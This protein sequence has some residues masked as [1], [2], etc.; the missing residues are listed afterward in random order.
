MGEQK[1]TFN[2]NGVCYPDEHYMVNLESRLVQI[3]ALVDRGK[4][5]V[6]N[7]GRQYGKTTVLQALG[8]CLCQEY[9][10]FSMDF[11]QMS[12]A[13]FQDEYRF[14]DA[15]INNVLQL[16][17]SKSKKTDGLAKEG[18]LMLEK[19]FETERGNIDLPQMFGCLSK[20]CAS[21][22]KPVVLIIDEVDNASNDQVFLDFLSQLRA[23]YLNR[24]ERTTFRSV[25]LAGVYD[26]KNLKQKIRIEGERKYNSP[27]NIA[28]DFDVE[29]SFSAKDIEGMLEEY[30]QDWHT[31]MNTAGMSKLIF[32]YTGGYPFLVSRI[33]QLIDEKLAGRE[34]YPDRSAAWTQRGVLEAVNM[35]LSMPSTLFD[36]MTKKLTDFPELKKML[37][38]M[39]FQGRKYTCE[40]EN[41]AISL[42]IMFGFLKNHD[43]IVVVANRIFETKL[44]NLFLSEGEI[45]DL[46]YDSQFPDKNQ[47]IRDGHLDMELIMEKFAEHYEEIYGDCTERF[48]E[49]NGR[50]LFLLYLRPIINGT[51]NY[52]IEAQT[53]DLRRTDVIIDYRGE[54]FVIELKIWHGEEYLK[55]GEQQLVD[56]LEYYKQEK[57]YLLSFSFNKKKSIDIRKM[58]VCGKEIVEVVV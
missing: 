47:F 15:F 11:Q 49:E 22:E 6:I 30:E 35:L 19:L 48:L 10:I 54:R 55:R 31:G 14:V 9:V 32:D 8:E 12:S 41:Q 56:Y 18:I 2:V 37:K 7:K 24:R 26:I 1:R 50:R 57:G 3:K 39:L 13:S 25:I 28:A 36:D 21:A 29:M 40:R 33:C 52:Y 44:Y 53:R 34:N 20:L 4:Y 27:W 45:E 38:G 46:K 23:L 5:F 43:N 51:G 17:H 42:G 16:I 58:Q